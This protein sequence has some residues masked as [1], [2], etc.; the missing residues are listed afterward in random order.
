MTSSLYLERRSPVHRLH[1]LSKILGVAVFFV[2][3]FSLE[4]PLSILPFTALLALTAAL[5]R[6]GES[7]VRLRALVVAVPLATFTIWVLFYNR[8]T[9]LVALGPLRVSRESLLFGA[10]MGLKLLS[11]LLL[12]VVLLATTRVEELTI[13]FAML[14]VPYRVGFALTLAFRLVPVFVDATGTVLQAQRLRSLD[15]GDRGRLERL[16]RAAPVVIPVFMGALRRADQMAIALELRGFSLP[17]KRSGILH[18]E[19]TWRDGVAIAIEL[20]ALWAA[21]TLRRLGLGLVG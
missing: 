15:E 10:G 7:L 18:L 17:G 13:A 19:W 8:G 2:A 14:G 20:A 5:G 1:P 11:F 6:T 16:R 4:Q 3:V 12:S 21:F 9:P